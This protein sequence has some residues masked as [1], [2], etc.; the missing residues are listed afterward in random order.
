MHSTRTRIANTANA[1]QRAS[2]KSAGVS[3]CVRAHNLDSLAQTSGTTHGLHACAFTFV[4]TC[5]VYVAFVA[6]VAFVRTERKQ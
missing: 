4:N 5:V 2:L 1:T 3:L 6:F